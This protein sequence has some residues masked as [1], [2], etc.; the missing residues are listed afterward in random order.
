MLPYSFLGHSRKGLAWSQSTVRR[1]DLTRDPAPDPPY[2]LICCRNAI[3]YFDRDT[4]DRLMH[5]FA[6]AL[7]PGGTLVLGKVEGILGPA[8]SRFELL[9]ARERIYRKGG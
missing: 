6:D 8:R 7:A 9:D 5:C 2:D 1:Q 3:I 4:Q